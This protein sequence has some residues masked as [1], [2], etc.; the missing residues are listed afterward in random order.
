M[1][2]KKQKA[3]VEVDAVLAAEQAK[4]KAETAK[5]RSA[6]LKA[7]DHRVKK[8]THRQLCG[9]LRSQARI[10]RD[11]CLLTSATAAAL[12]IMLNSNLPGPSFSDKHPK[13]MRSFT[14]GYEK[15][16]RRLRA[17]NRR[18]LAKTKLG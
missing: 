15:Q 13:E 12:L 16:L 8:M 18:N 10:P 1:N 9:D 6:D 4:A 5:K 11:T 17:R 3:A 2:E 7:Y 14:L